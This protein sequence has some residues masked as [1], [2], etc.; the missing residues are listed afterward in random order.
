MEIPLGSA[1]MIAVGYFDPGN[2]S[3]DLEAGSKF[4]YDLLWIMLVA[5]GVAIYLQHLCVRLPFNRGKDLAQVSCLKRKF[6]TTAGAILNALLYL[7]IEAAMVATDLAQIIGSAMALRMLLGVPLFW[8]CVISA[9]DVILV[10]FIFREHKKPTGE[11]EGLCNSLLDAF[12]A[13]LMIFVA[14]C[15]IVELVMLRKSIK[16]GPLLA[17]TFIPKIRSWEYLTATMGI[18]GATVMPHNLYLHSAL[19]RRE[20]EAERMKMSGGPGKSLRKRT[21]EIAAALAAAV[22]VNGGILV[23]AAAVTEKSGVQLESLEKV[24]DYLRGSLGK[25]S[26]TLFALG[27]L[28]AGVSA[29]I[30]G[31]LSGQAVIEGFFED[32]RLMRH[33]MQWRNFMLRGITLSLALIL[34]TLSADM[35]DRVLFYSQVALSLQ[36]PIAIV[37]LIYAT[38]D[39]MNRPMR[40]FSWAI[41]ALIILMNI[42]LVLSPLINTK[43][44]SAN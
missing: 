20:I 39:S 3:T 34:A 17:G 10:F 23:M 27:L 30:A 40:A 25:L 24:A 43:A 7:A 6:P 29:T 2:W 37:P 42:S 8:G 33:G 41:A 5:N 31:T 21:L 4:G 19:T 35:A 16:L 44:S 36:L 11:P 1:W 32:S 18:V 12:V 13:V 9:L 22:L 14:G 28:A 15:V 26:A 38:Q